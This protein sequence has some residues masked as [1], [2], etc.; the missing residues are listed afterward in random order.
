M[1][2]KTSVAA[3]PVRRNIITAPPTNIGFLPSC[4]NNYISSKYGTLIFLTI[5]FCTFSIK[6]VV[7]MVPQRLITPITIAVTNGAIPR[8]Q[9][10]GS[11]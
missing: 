4:N 5:Y 3:V 10:N 11:E 7:K 1:K 8:E 2:A 9:N 6:S